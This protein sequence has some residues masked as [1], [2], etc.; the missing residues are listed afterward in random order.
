MR[1]VLTIAEASNYLRVNKA[2]IYKLAQQGSMPAFKVG[3][4]WRFKRGEIEAWVDENRNN[5]KPTKSKN[6]S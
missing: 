3:K 5:R 6:T 1:E 2:T 4:V